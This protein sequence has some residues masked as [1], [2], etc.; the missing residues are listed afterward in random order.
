[1]FGVA[2]FY[3]LILHVERRVC[4]GLRCRMAGAEGV[5]ATLRANGEQAEP[6]SCL[7]QCDRPVAVLDAHHELLPVGPEVGS[8]PTIRSCP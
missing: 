2:S 8:V 5:L 3:H 1:V 7:G 4:Q 6:V